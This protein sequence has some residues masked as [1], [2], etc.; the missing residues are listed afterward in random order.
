M[1]RLLKR[2]VKQVFGKEFNVNDFDAK[3]LE[4]LEHVRETYDNFDKEKNFLNHTVNKNKREL[5][6]LYDSMII[7]SRLAGI[8]EMMENITHQWKQPLS[9]I[10]NLISLLKLELKDNK[11]LEIIEEQTKYL[12]KTIADF[13]SFSSHSNEENSLFELEKS[14]D[15]TIKLFTFQAKLNRIIVNK[16]LE[17]GLLQEGHMG[18]FNQALLVILANA[19]DAFISNGTVNRVIEIETKSI[20]NSVVISIQDNAGGILEKNINKI[21]EPYFTTKF[22]DKGTGIGLSM[23]YN[24]IKDMKGIINVKNCKNGALFYITLPEI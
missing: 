8:G 7:S 20:N 2:Q 14:I 11:E 17:K 15:E 23:T 16:N 5:K 24:I 10:L 4:L 12:D 18:K 19:K 13:K 1:H 22:K 9:I 21:F 6:E 3:T